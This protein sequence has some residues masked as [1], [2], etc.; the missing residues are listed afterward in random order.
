MKVT[1]V[2]VLILTVLLVFSNAVLMRETFR[3]QKRVFI[4]ESNYKHLLHR[5]N[6]IEYPEVLGRSKKCGISG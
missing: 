6:V 5:L 1:I 3:L 4:A 2:I